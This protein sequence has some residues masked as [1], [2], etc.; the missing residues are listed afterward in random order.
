MILVLV[1]G[2]FF[3]EPLEG[4]DFLDVHLENN[5]TDKN[6]S[7]FYPG[8][9]HRFFDLLFYCFLMFTFKIDMLTCRSVQDDFFDVSGW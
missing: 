9:Q 3:F 7:G 5:E 2:H 8:F 1:G 6:E 4:L